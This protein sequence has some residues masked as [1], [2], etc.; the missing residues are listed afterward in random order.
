L[1]EELEI[2][3]IACDTLLSLE[4]QYPDKKVC[5]HFVSCTLEEDE[6]LY[7]TIKN[8]RVGWFKPN[9]FPFEEFCPAD[10]IAAHRLPWEKLFKV[11][12]INE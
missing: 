1:F 11:R 2:G 10:K 6:G 9:Q 5:L 7:K 8:P 4:H 3:I 12:K